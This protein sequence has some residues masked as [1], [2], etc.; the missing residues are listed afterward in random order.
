[1]KKLKWSKVTGV[2]LL[3]CAAT[4][5]S[6][7]AQTLTTLTAFDGTNGSDP[8]A[9]LIQG[10]D[11]NLY[12]TTQYGG[13]ASNCESGYPCGTVFKITPSG[14]LTTLHSFNYGDGAYP[15]SPLVQGSDGNFYGTNQGEADSGGAGTIFKITPSGTLAVLLYSFSSPAG[16]VQGRDGNFYGTTPRSYTHGTVFK[17]T[18]S[19]TL[20]TLYTFQ[21]T[22]GDNPQAGLIQ[23]TD[24]YFYGTT[25][26]GG[27]S[28]NCGGGCGT[29]FKITPSGSL[30]TL[31]SFSVSDGFNVVAGLVQGSDGN[32]YGTTVGG[33]AGQNGGVVFKITPSGTFSIV[34]SL[35][36]QSGCTDGYSPRAGLV[37]ASDGNFYGTTSGG[38]AKGQG[39]VFAV[40]PGGLLTTLYSFCAQSGCAD[41]TTPLAGVI[42]ASDG[43]FY[44]TTYN[45]GNN[46]SGTVFRLQLTLDT[47]TV[48]TS[49]KGVVTSTDG[50]INC[51]ATCSHS[52]FHDAPVTLHATPASGWAFTGWGGACSGADSCNVTMTQDLSVS[53]G[54]VQLPV[55]LTVSTAG[56]GSVTSTD[57][58][59]DC[60]STCSHTYSPGAQ[61]K[62]NAS[63]NQ[64]WFLGDGMAGASALVPAHLP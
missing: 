48:T 6:S 42:Q 7:P 13:S 59:I 27:T 29:V 3:F 52:Y 40:T 64:G 41:G 63:P 49:G 10:S 1:M 4:A 39:T 26:S 14:T 44:G 46:N 43:N 21:G 57:G 60:P 22:D 5:I 32:F 8:A 45:G 31:H 12:G 33:G 38:G 36:S 15:V 9:S 11:G 51:P 55:T 18:P 25:E 58:F 2:V 53:A 16:L 35:C 47:L 34:Y 17:V 56:S 28:N 19:G 23:A 62:L 61:V 50:F 37:Q 54:F 20:T 30:T 24:G